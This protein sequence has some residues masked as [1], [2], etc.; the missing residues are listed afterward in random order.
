MKNRDSMV[1][2]TCPFCGNVTLLP[3]NTEDFNAWQAGALIQDVMPYMEPAERETL[4]SG[5]CDECQGRM[6][7]DPFDDDEDFIDED[8]DDE[9]DDIDSDEGF[10]P[11]EGCFTFDC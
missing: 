3:V 7:K 5:L 4:I 10:D 1:Q 11:Y 9:P 2:V 6:F 8:W